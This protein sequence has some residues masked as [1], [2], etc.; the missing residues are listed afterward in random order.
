MAIVVESSQWTGEYDDKALGSPIVWGEFPDREALDR[1][2]TR[3]QSEPWFR[4]TT[5][6][7][8]AGNHGRADNDQ[9]IMPDENPAG[10]DARNLRQNFVG[11]AAASTSMLA[12]GIV[13]S[14]GGAALPAV[15]AAAAAGVATTAVGEVAGLSLNPVGTG[16]RP[17]SREQADHAEGPALGIR[18]DTDDLC[19]KA[20]AFLQNSG[21]RQVWVQQT[22]AG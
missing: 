16:Q 6:Q 15:A 4:D 3:I 1:V 18:V 8:Q 5:S 7:M 14:T 22:N 2:A 10:T 20:K 13:I 21:A 9:L 12:A 19:E 11:L 17:D